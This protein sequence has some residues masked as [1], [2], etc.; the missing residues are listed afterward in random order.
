MSFFSFSW[1]RAPVVKAF[2]RTAPGLPT[3][4]M[5]RY[6][7]CVIGVLTMIFCCC[8]YV[9][10]ST[11]EGTA[12]RNA[13]LQVQAL[14]R[15]IEHAID[16]ARNQ[17]LFLSAASHITA[18]DLLIRFSYRTRV[19]PGQF[20]EIAFIG[21]DPE[22]R[23]VL[24]NVDGKVVILPRPVAESAVNQPFAE[25][26]DIRTE[27]EVSVGRPVQ[28]TYTM[29][30]VGDAVQNVSYSVLRFYT[31]VYDYNNNFQGMLLLSLDLTILR[32][33]LTLF[34]S[35][36]SPMYD[37]QSDFKHV[38]SVF[39]DTA[40]WM[41]F[42]SE[43][44]ESKGAPL[45]TEALRSGLN[46]DSGRPGLLTAF[47][48]APQHT[49]YWDVVSEITAGKSGQL[50]LGSGVVWGGGRS[51]ADFL[52]YAPV[53]Y[54]TVGSQ[55]AHVLGGVITLDTSYAAEQ[56]TS[57]LY[58]VFSICTFLGGAGLLAM[59][60]WGAYT[61]QGYVLSLS[62]HIQEQN[63]TNGT[64]T[65]PLRA[66]PEDFCQLSD[67][68]GSVFLRLREAMAHKNA[69]E[70]K[71]TD[72]WL[73][74]LV[75]NIPQAAE[76]P[77]TGLVGESNAMAELRLQIEKAAPIFA[78]VLVIGE[79]GTGKE[80]VSQALHSISERNKGPFISI[81]C[82]ALDEN[83]LMD[84]LFGHVKGAFSDAHV[85]RKGAFIAAE[86]GTLMLDEIG[87]A[88]TKVQQ[89]LLRALSTRQICPLGSDKEIPFNTRIVAATNV[90]LRE[91]VQQG[92]FREDLY[93]RLAVFTIHTCPLRER[94][95]DI[96][97]LTNYFVTQASEE[98]RR[99]C[100]GL[101]R[102]ALQKMQ[103]YDWPGNVRQLRNTL[104]RAL[105]YSNDGIIRAPDIV[106]ADGVAAAAEHAANGEEKRENGVQPYDLLFAELNSR[107]RVL[108]PV[109]FTKGSV[110]RSEY[111]AL[112]ADTI[113]TRTAQY[114]LQEL[115]QRG[116][117][118]KKGVGP[119]SYYELV[120]TN[121]D[122]KK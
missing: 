9:A 112:V 113:S 90:D 102:G 56:N 106:F 7:P 61:I 20:R 5:V 62:E 41:L 88:T 33:A 86:G 105:A 78:D 17:I 8:G 85:E 117:L 111:Q 100:A 77:A 73:Q 50:A 18:D 103:K 74:E 11:L 37:N 80:L 26:P 66:M 15:E 110:T 35:P 120:A 75:P 57:M 10:K 49:F 6:F 63:T 121:I 22:N 51:M 68:I 3:W 82:G 36:S 25:L 27:G 101:T 64:A 79:T 48:P 44:T 92:R 13:Q 53:T 12:S 24:L 34:S 42:Q 1:L 93:Y 81:N 30:P 69:S 31:P 4:A 43:T 95:E 55:T 118:R 91:E 60:Y 119:A 67:R 70:E 65:P 84:S 83:L 40:G 23:M 52:S 94:K 39:V 28:T 116:L 14:C 54:T 38:R 21:R 89:A 19:K 59:A 71:R 114:D 29:V 76:F 99:P 104:T 32:D 96:E 109:L 47:R 87:N 107:Q 115:V 122:E 45:S 58:A 97:Q 16:D 108:L 46:G 2:Q 72:R 98:M